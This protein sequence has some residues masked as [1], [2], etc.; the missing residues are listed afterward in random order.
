MR[1]ARHIRSMEVTAVV[2]LAVG[3][4]ISS[5]P[6]AS[7]TTLT[8]SVTCES[9][10]IGFSCDGYAS[11][12]T[13]VYTFSWSKPTNTRTDLATSSSVTVRCPVG[14]GGSIM[15][16]VRDSSGATASASGFSR[17]GGSD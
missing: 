15:F 3:S 9:R 5:A 10:P 1:T 17:C 11:G 2:A 13:G 16:T 8:A 7:A 4:V 12:G 6:P 14:T